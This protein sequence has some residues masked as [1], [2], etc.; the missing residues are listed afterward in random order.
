M[1]A[2]AVAGDTGRCTWGWRLT[3]LGVNLALGVPGVVPVWLVWYVLANGPFAEMG[4][5]LRE[6]TENDGMLLW[7]VIVVPVVA[8]FAGIWWLANDPVCRRAG[9]APRLYWPGGVLLTL[10]PTLLLVV[11]SFV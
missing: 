8:V 4:W 2:E 1:S 6:P 9:L 5:T 3:A 11:D 10:V 7:L